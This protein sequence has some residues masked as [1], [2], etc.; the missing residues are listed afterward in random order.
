MWSDLSHTTAQKRRRHTGVVADAEG[1][2][3]ERARTPGTR[4]AWTEAHTIAAT[5]GVAARAR[6]DPAHT[7]SQ[8]VR[9][10]AYYVEASWRE[11]G[12]PRWKRAGHDRRGLMTR[13]TA[14]GRS[15]MRARTNMSRPADGRGRRVY[16]LFAYC[17]P[18]KCPARLRAIDY[19]GG[20][21][22]SRSGAVW[23]DAPSMIQRRGPDGRGGVSKPGAG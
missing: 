12:G 4:P 1:W 2:R 8:H 13:G 6:A 15:Q 21:G 11:T 20:S 5:R 14:S 22:S 3:P 18:Q 17:I 16:A 19:G 7:A 10:T 9:S 23:G